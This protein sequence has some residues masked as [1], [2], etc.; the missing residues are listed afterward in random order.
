MGHRDT[1]IAR[2][3]KWG[4]SGTGT[5]HR[6]GVY[7]TE[8]LCKYDLQLSTVPRKVSPPGNQCVAHMYM[9]IVERSDGYD[10]LRHESGHLS[11]E[12]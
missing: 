11:L 3:C 9:E 7:V 2:V 12:S 4:P 8:F 10:E 5:R 6:W 1:W